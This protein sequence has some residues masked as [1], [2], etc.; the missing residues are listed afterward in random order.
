MTGRTIW[1]ASYPKS[2]NTWF[3]A[4][5]SAVVGTGTLDINRMAGGP[6]GADVEAFERVLG[7][8]TYL[9]SN[10]EIQLLRPRVDEA[11]DRA[12][13][14]LRF[15]KIHDALH[16]GPSGEPIVSVAATRGAIYMIRDPRDVAV[17]LAHHQSV[18]LANAS[19]LVANGRDSRSRTREAGPRL[20]DNTLPQYVG[21][22]SEHVCSWTEAPPFPVHT[23]RYEDC[24][25]DP[26]A[27]FGEAFR[28]VGLEVSEEHLLRAV[29]AASFDRLRAQEEATEF[30][31][32]Q[33]DA[34]FF[35]RGRIG[36]WLSELPPEEAR[37]IEHSHG[38]LMA[39]FGY[40]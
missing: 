26:E 40:L 31:E 36:S 15:R 9:L 3:R 27:A 16:A 32:R 33:G 14:D 25:E 5:Y 2:G 6:Q 19:R 39:R 34:H 23:L 24:V 30:Y 10:Q 21:G 28:A 17:S 38:N 1:L 20:A 13:S 4:V 12:T 18:P 7:V 22:W 37:R 11:L 8:P 35:R 29:E